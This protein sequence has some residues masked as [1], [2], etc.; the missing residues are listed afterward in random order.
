MKFC[1]A[2]LHSIINTQRRQ[3]KHEHTERIHTN[4]GSHTEMRNSEQFWHVHHSLVSTTKASIFIHTDQTSRTL[5]HTQLWL[6][7]A[8]RVW[9]CS[10]THETRTSHNN[11]T[12]TT[13]GNPKIL[14]ICLLH[15]NQT[16]KVPQN[17]WK[18]RSHTCVSLSSTNAASEQCLSSFCIILSSSRC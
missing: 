3:Q 8:G 11:M 13:C 15:P 1:S 9:V 5:S 4:H 6:V 16:S 17:T 14:Q 12:V 10:D 2:D 18:E 7:C